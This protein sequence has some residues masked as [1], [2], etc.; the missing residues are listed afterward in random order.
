M[1]AAPDA[2]TTAV[3]ALRAADDKKGVELELLDVADLL[4]VVDL[5]ALVTATNERHLKAVADAVEEAVRET[6]DRRPLRREGTP[7]SGWILLDYGDVVVHLFHS[8]QRDFYALE[9]LWSDVPRRDPVSGEVV[10]RDVAAAAG[11]VVG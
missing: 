11:D 4:A 7:A 2:V 1:P 9:R 8:D 5:F 10:G 6:E 3:T